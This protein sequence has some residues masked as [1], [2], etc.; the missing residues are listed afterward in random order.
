[1]KRGR[2]RRDD[3]E[4]AAARA[5]ELLAGSLSGRAG[6]VL[7]YHRVGERPGDPVRELVPALAVDEFERHVRLVAE[8]YQPVHASTLIEHVGSRGGVARVPVALTF[9]DDLYS[10]IEF[11]APILV[12]AG[13][14]ATFF[15]GGA[16]LDG[17]HLFWWEHLQAL[18]DAHGPNQVAAEVG[19]PGPAGRSIHTLARTIESL[20]P[21]RRREVE[22]MLAEA[23]AGA[24]AVQRLDR[25]GV[26][27]LSRDGFEIGFHTLRHELLPALPDDELRC[28]L[29]EGRQALADAAGASVDT[30]AYPHGKADERV[31]A[32]AR[33]AGYRNGFTGIRGRVTRTTK[34]LLVPRNELRAGPRPFR[35]AIAR[36]AARIDDRSA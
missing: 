6:V 15:L 2:R 4:R 32:A 31:A 22:R 1:V 23:D 8:R 7:V 12:A 33:A 21:P 14:P 34:P 20:D 16:T 5:L 13:V 10:H 19:V 11:A 28:A 3:L 18:V 29:V 30:V 17:P 27:R 9:D 25:I 36:L 26:A 24:V 35:L